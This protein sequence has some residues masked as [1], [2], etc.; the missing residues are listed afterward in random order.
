MTYKLRIPHINP[1]C[2][3]RRHYTEAEAGAACDEMNVRS[4]RLRPT[5]PPCVVFWRE[6]CKA[7]HIGRAVI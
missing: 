3:K 2:G 6:T 1:V 7:W 4:R 5:Q